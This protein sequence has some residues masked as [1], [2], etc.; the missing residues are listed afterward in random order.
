MIIST[1]HGQKHFQ[2]VAVVDVVRTGIRRSF[3]SKFVTR[4]SDDMVAECTDYLAE[5]FPSLT[6]QGADDFIVGC[7]FPEGA[8]GFNL[9]RNCVAVSS[10]STEVPGHTVNRYC[11]SGLQAVVNGAA[12]IASGNS[13]LIFAAGVESVAMVMPHV[14]TMFMRNPRIVE[15]LPTLYTHLFDDEETRPFVKRAGLNMVGYAETAA[16]M[17]SICRQEQDDHSYLMQERAQ[18]AR[19]R[20]LFAEEI[21]PV[22]PDELRVDEFLLRSTKRTDFDRF[23]PVIAGENTV[24]ARNSAPLAEG[25][26]VAMLA[27][28]DLAQS[29]S[30]KP[31]GY[32][33]A[34][35]VCATN[36]ECMGLGASQA[37]RKL[38]TRTGIALDDIDLLEI[39]EPF[40]AIGLA[41]LQQLG[42]DRKRVNPNGNA[43]ALGHPYGM[44]GTRIVGALLRELNRTGGRF[45]ITAACIGGGMG[46]AALFVRT[47][48]DTDFRRK[49]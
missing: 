48:D 25:A 10:L 13:D 27:T 32:F 41:T 19:A 26:S 2:P 40:A 12:S 23:S 20:G 17:F 46:I 29:H 35:T 7:A 36:P 49:A 28:P 18:N 6:S 8:Q 38:L 30:I 15:Q 14:N 34:Y 16:K 5:K 45:G 24:T 44:S 11:G 9:G 3:K 39:N 47:M 1:K 42:L 37:I 31:L 33:L 4:R 21:I 22:G 43:L